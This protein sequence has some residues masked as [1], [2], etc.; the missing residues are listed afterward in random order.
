M[1]NLI[2]IYPLRNEF[3]SRPAVGMEQP[4]MLSCS[5]GNLS[6]LQISRIPESDTKSLTVFDT[7]TKVFHQYSA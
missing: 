3:P 1:L 2:E 7:K 6:H 4:H 5:S